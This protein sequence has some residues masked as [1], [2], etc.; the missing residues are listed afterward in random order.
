[1]AAAKNR[2]DE[3]NESPVVP[4]DERQAIV[5]PQFREDLVHWIAVEPRTA[6]RVMRLVE[7]VVRNPFLGIGK[8]EALKFDQQGHWSRRVTDADRLVYLA[9]GTAIYFIAARHHYGRR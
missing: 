1:M 9:R 6:M 8:P 3:R 2:R 4:S 5:L 7:E